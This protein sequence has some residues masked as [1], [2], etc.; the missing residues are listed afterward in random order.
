MITIIPKQMEIRKAAAEKYNSYGSEWEKAY[1]DTYSGGYNVYHKD[2][3]FST[4]GGKY[5]KEVG[6]LLAQEGKQVEFLT[7]K[8]QN[9]KHP[10]IKFDNQT[11]DIKSIIAYTSGSI[12]DSIWNGKKANNVIFYFTN[13]INMG[14]I[15][16]GYRRAYGRFSKFG[17]LDMIPTLYYLDENG[18]LIKYK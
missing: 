15:E 9:T 5:E 12:M 2:H 4:I 3:H 13:G 18:R 17:K 6:K 16:K 8:G 1:F 14:I 7:E 10:D 11:W